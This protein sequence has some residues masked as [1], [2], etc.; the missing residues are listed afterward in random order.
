MAGDTRD[1][2]YTDRLER[3]RTVWWKRYV[4]QQAP[5][6]WKLN[7]LA[8]GRMLEVGCGIGRNLANYRGEAVGVDHNE[9]SVSQCVQAGHVAYTVEDFTQAESTGAFDTLLL[10]HVVEHMTFD[11]ALGLLREYLPYVAASG[12]VIVVTPQELGYASDPT[13][14]E[15]FDLGM[16]ERLFAAAD[17]RTV[18]LESF[19]FPRRVGRLFKYNE[20]VGVATPAI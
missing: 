9:H 12:T 16:L 18:R 15:F 20:F 6:R 14:V 5:Y 4:D 11:D 2:S 10:S 8:T 7:R 1:S 17:L 13:H 3:L 19:P